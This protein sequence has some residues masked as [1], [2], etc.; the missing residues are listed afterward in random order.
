MIF[1][2]HYFQSISKIIKT[3]NSL[4]IL[5]LIFSIGICPIEPAHNQIN[6]DC[7][8]QKITIDNLNKNQIMYLDENWNDEFL[9]DLHNRGYD[10]TDM[11]IDKVKLVSLVNNCISAKYYS[12]L[13]KNRWYVETKLTGF[14][15]IAAVSFIFTDDH[16]VNCTE[17]TDLAERIKNEVGWK[18][19]F[20]KEVNELFYLQLSFPGPKL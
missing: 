1:G 20:N 3:M 14:G 9:P 8:L 16:G 11:K 18:L 4:L 12:D 10:L 17:F 7:K 6:T 19:T 5:F 2:N 13:N 15:K